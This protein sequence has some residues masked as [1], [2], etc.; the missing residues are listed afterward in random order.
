MN[1]MQQHALWWLALAVALVVLGMAGCDS[2]L[3]SKDEEVKLGQQAGDDFEHQ[4]G[5]ETDP[6]L[7][8]LVASIAKNL[9]RVTEPP[10]YPY[11]YRVLAD[12]TVNAAAF[13]GGRIYVFRGLINKVNSNPDEVAWVLAHETTHVSRQHAIRRIEKQLGYE[14]IIALVLGQSD[15]GKIASVVGGLV[16]LDY[17]R[18]NEYEADRMGMLY[19][20]KA[21]YD[22]TA[23]VAVLEL[24]QK[25]QKNEPSKL[26]IMF[27]THPGNNDR[28]NH[29][30]DYL[31]NMGW[32]GAYYSP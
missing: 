17:G 10:D 6:R 27:A 28:I 23:S 9:E 20:Y 19:S 32:S 22:P 31:T 18:D 2:R 1:R 7:N 5:R 21:G 24:F 3:I 14:T 11:D 29:S 13:P 15:A 30:K 4:Y 16:L 8:A 12:D 26:E 25:L